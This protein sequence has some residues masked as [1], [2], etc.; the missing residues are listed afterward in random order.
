MS[1]ILAFPT[2]PGENWKT[3]GGFEWMH[4][5]GFGPLDVHPDG[6]FD[7]EPGNPRDDLYCL[8]CDGWREVGET[9]AFEDGVTVE[10]GPFR[11]CEW[12]G[13]TGAAF[14]IGGEG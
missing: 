4:T 9:A 5:V 8:F 14:E 13:G 2:K 6:P 10:R 7:S 11:L 3:V 1:N 12:C